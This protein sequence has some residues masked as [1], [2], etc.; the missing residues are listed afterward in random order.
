[1]LIEL[2]KKGRLIEVISSYYSYS[3]ETKNKR[4]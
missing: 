4:A 2:K 1:M 3:G